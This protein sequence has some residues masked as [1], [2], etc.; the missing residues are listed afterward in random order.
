M[1]QFVQFLGAFPSPWRQNCFAQSFVRFRLLWNQ[2]RFLS[3]FPFNQIN[4]SIEMLLVATLH[5]ETLC[6]HHVFYVV[7]LKSSFTSWSFEQVRW[8]LDFWCHFHHGCFHLI[9]QYVLSVSQNVWLRDTKTQAMESHLTFPKPQTPLH[10]LQ[11]WGQ[12]DNIHPSAHVEHDDPRN[13]WN[14]MSWLIPNPH[15]VLCFL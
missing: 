8:L 10:C 12:L 13:F 11:L 3:K 15:G 4:W 14:F 1:T 2:R 5:F 7:Y 9:T 6:M